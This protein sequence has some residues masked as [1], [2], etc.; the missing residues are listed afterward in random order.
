MGVNRRSFIRYASLAAAGSAAGLRP[1]GAL[2]SLAQSATDYKVL[3]C[4]FLFGGNDANNT[5]IQFDTTGYA[6][7]SSVRGPLALP[8]NSL[9]QL[10]HA[11]NF[12]LH[13][14]L[15]TLRSCSTAKQRH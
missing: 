15:P 9:I 1:F 12:A 6:N 8:Q 5:L 11:P 13:P 4:V 2:N 3:V 10:A 7:Y 14:S